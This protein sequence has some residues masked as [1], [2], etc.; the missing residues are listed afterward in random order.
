MLIVHGHRYGIGQNTTLLDYLIETM[1]LYAG[2]CGY[3][4]V[5][6]GF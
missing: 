2:G 5:D 3:E 4:S 6:T 1:S